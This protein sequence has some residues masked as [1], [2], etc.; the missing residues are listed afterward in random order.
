MNI[1]QALVR[2]LLPLL[3]IAAAIGVASWLMSTK[4]QS[5]QRPVAEQGLLV[6]VQAVERGAYTVQVV[7]QGTVVP[8]QAIELSPEITGRVEWKNPEL[9]AGGHVA[10]G[11]ALVRVDRRDFELAL[12]QRRAAVAQA[13]AELELEQGRKRVA[14]KEWALFHRKDAG[15]PALA[16]R[17][18]QL[19]SVE[20]ALES[21]RHALEQAKL[22]LARTELRAPFN[23]IVRQNMTEVGRLVGPAQPM[24]ELV[25]SDL[26]L[27]EVSLALADLQWLRIPGVGQPLLTPAARTALTTGTGAEKALAKQTTLA[28]VRQQVGGSEILRTGFVTRLLGDLDPVGRMARLLVAIRDPLGL[29]GDKAG[30]TELPLLLGAY[31]QVTLHGPELSDVVAVPR[32]ALRQGERVYVASPDNRLEIR[33]VQVLRREQEHVLVRAGFS[34]GERLIVSAIPSAVPGMALRVQPV[35]AAA[36]GRTD[37]AQRGA[38]GVEP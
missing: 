18:P 37:L 8:E 30:A 15:V 3:L 27:V 21:A 25:G 1:R 28:T 10:A 24:A 20:L 32:Q 22:T 35:A 17:E 16:Q 12:A 6:E 13:E 26:F 36:E 33:Q 7:A 29:Q 14:E 38:E 19:R 5:K 9:T 23:A 4:P 11:E 2:G 34:A 31:V